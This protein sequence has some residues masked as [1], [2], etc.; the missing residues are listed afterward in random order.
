MKGQPPSEPKP[1]RLVRFTSKNG[2]VL[3]FEDAADGVIITLILGSVQ[4]M[5]WPRGLEIGKLVR[6][7]WN[8]YGSYRGWY[9]AGV[10]EAGNSSTKSDE[11]RV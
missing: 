9:V 3:N 6:L 11:N 8:C 5:C 2:Q 1:P 10:L 7:E 4:C